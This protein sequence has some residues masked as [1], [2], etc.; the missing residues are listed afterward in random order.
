MELCSRE[1]EPRSLVG[2]NVHWW[3][4]PNLVLTYNRNN[5]DAKRGDK[6]MAT[7][8]REVAMKNVL[9]YRALGSLCRQHAAYNPDESWKLLAQAEYWEHLAQVEMSSHFEDCNATGSDAK[10]VGDKAINHLAA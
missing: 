8:I 7:G 2:S 1:R 3:T 6:V 4:H 10:P 5:P 9:R